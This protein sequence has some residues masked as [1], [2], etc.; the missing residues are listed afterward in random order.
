MLFLFNIFFFFFENRSLY[1]IIRKIIVQPDRLQM[2]I[3]RMC[4]A[5]W[6]P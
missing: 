6:L 2:T 4:L 5:C 3:Q 1:E